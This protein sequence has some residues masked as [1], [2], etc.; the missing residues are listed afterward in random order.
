MRMDRGNGCDQNLE[1][2]EKTW[3]AVW[4]LLRPLQAILHVAA[5]GTL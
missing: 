2:V 3:I 1:N 4:S 5:R